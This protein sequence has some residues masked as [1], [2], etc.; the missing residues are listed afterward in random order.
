[1][2]LNKPSYLTLQENYPDNDRF[3]RG[4]LFDE[5][6]W[7]DLKTNPTYANTCA[8]RMSY[9]LIRSGVSLPGR[10]RIKTG[11]HKGKLIEPSQLA[12]SKILAKNTLFG[13]PEKFKYLDRDKVMKGRHGILSFMKIPGY[14][15]DGNLSGHIDLIDWRPATF[16]GMPLWWDVLHCDLGCHWD[17]AE[18]W[19]WALP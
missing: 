10:M 4:K 6:G 8:I 3:P 16:L 1:M 12:L 17:S 7:G 18:F 9:C 11:K 14:V 5:L 2:P 15:V 19:F 13:E